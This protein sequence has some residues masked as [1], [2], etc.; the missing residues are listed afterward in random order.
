MIVEKLSG[1]ASVSSSSEEDYAV[2]G[3]H[4]RHEVGEAA[5]MPE[6][7][8]VFAESGCHLELLTCLDM[9][10]DEEVLC[11][12][13]QFNRHGDPERHVLHARL[14]PGESATSISSCFPGADWYEREVFDMFGVDFTGHPDLKRILMEEDYTGHPLLKDFADEDPSRSE[15]ASDG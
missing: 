8:A 7:A 4:Y 15:L 5:A 14:A 6:I 2:K 12:V 1:M 10:A 11:I 3:Y 9:R 13:Y